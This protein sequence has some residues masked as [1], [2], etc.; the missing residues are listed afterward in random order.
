MCPCP[1]LTLPLFDFPYEYD[2]LLFLLCI[3]RE[4]LDNKP[5][6]LQCVGYSAIHIHEKNFSDW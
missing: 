3:H 1:R 4:Y 5:L 2:A 6:K